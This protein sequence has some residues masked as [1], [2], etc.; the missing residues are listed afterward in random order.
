MPKMTEHTFGDNVRIHVQSGSRRSFDIA[1]ELAM[2]GN[3]AT[4]YRVDGEKGLVFYWVQ[5]D[6]REDVIPLPCEMTVEAVSAFAWA[7]LES[8]PDEEYHEE[9]DHDGSNGRGWRVYNEAWNRVGSEWQTSFA[10]LPVWIWYG[11]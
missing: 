2:R 4:H 10:V 6:G 5:P 9:L 3:K 1:I 11:K 7:W 8:R